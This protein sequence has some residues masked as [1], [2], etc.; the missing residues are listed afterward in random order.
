MASPPPPPQPQLHCAGTVA[1]SHLSC[2]P[3]VRPVQHP[4]APCSRHA[5]SAPA[6]REL[7]QPCGL[8]TGP[9]KGCPPRDWRG[10][11]AYARMWRP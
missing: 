7:G 8:W 4:R 3:F 2:S 5:I 11:Q 10:K 9:I 1:A 6:R